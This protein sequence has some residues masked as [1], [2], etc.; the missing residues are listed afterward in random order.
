MITNL[1]EIIA[2]QTI[3]RMGPDVANVNILT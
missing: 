2:T 1:A 3:S